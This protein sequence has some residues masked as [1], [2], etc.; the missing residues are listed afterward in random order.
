VKG[1]SWFSPCRPDDVVKGLERHVRPDVNQSPDLR[2]SEPRSLGAPSVSGTPPVPFWASG[3]IVPEQGRS[4]AGGG[5]QTLP[6]VHDV[7]VGR[8]GHVGKISAASSAT[9]RRSGAG[10]DRS[11][12][13]VRS[14]HRRF[15]RTARAEYRQSAPLRNVLSQ[16]SR[17]FSD[18]AG[19]VFACRSRLKSSD[20]RVP[21]RC[22][23]IHPIGCLSTH[24]LGSPGRSARSPSGGEAIRRTDRDRGSRCPRGR[25]RRRIS[26]RGRAAPR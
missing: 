24:A 16:T 5:T 10:P 2:A 22:S 11:A 8:C 7:R 25:W 6:Q 13:S 23:P 15:R 9:G 3:G 19:P 20:E 17:S 26:A 18:R 14:N 12:R 21:R 1:G 4:S